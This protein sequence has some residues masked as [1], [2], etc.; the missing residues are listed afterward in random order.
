MLSPASGPAVLRQGD[1]VAN[2]YLVSLKIKP[3]WSGL[4]TRIRSDLVRRAKNT[5]VLYGV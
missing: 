1:D 5:L 3:Q 4:L 2:L